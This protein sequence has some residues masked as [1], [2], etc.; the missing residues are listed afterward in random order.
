M[1]VASGKLDIG[2][3]ISETFRILG[4]NT[5]SFVIVVAL[6]SLLPGLVCGAI[7]LVSGEVVGRAL[8]LVANVIGAIGSAALIWLAAEVAQGAKPSASEALRR[9][10][11]RAGS[12]F[13][14]TLLQMIA[15][16][17]GL[18]ILVFPGLL[19]ACMWAV[20]PVAL[21][22]G[23]TRIFES[24]GVSARLTKGSRLRVLGLVLIFAVA[25]SLLV[26]LAVIPAL[27]PGLGTNAAA[28]DV[29][30]GSVAGAVIY[31]ITA[32]G[33]VALY[34]ELVRLKDGVTPE[35]IAKV[36]D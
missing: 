14:L 19:L 32:I 25:M 9:G 20:A 16:V 18:V 10:L 2:K 13:V 30:A 3:V 27:V 28:L 22:V 7:E 34:N 29:V 15:I 12:L 11:S 4:E 33:G 1:G 6:T 23:K 26:A 36:F 21:V 17:A 5:L 35:G 31:L 8:N 24:F